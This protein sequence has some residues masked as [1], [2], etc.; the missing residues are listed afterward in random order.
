MRLSKME[1]IRWAFRSEA[2]RPTKQEWLLALSLVQKEEKERVMRFVFKKDA[3]SSLMLA[4]PYHDL[5]LART[6]KGKPFLVNK[7]TD[8]RLKNFS[9]NVSHQGDF[10]VLAAEPCCQVGVDVMKTTYPG[11]T[12]VQGF[13]HLMRKQ[14]TPREWR[15]V[16]S[17]PTE[18]TQLQMF[19]RHWCLKES[20]VKAV[21]VGI[22]HDLQAVEFNLP[23]R[24]LSTE[25]I[26][27]DSQLY[28]KGS[29]SHDWSFQETKLD[30]EHQVAVALGALDANIS[31]HQNRKSAPSFQQLN[32]KE[33]I[34]TGI[35]WQ[36]SDEKDWD[37]YLQK[38]E[39]FKQ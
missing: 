11:G 34:C 28:L 1:G 12:D 9:F 29:I 30:E 21:G 37:V 13:F 25:E 18:W 38:K 17:Q 24:L 20:Y 36:E 4:V 15:T 14:F 10:T 2:W 26:T 27:C 3:K 23:T 7:I 22:G 6:E 16:N 31:K 35:P 32:F 39:T 5:Q 8:D 33:V 19:Y